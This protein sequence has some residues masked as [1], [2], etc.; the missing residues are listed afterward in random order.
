MGEALRPARRAES[1]A[2]GAHTGR[3]VGQV[4]WSPRSPML[5]PHARRDCVVGH[6]AGDRLSLFDG[7]SSLGSAA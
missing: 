6:I 2:G 4:V 5:A 3:L 7:T 1:F